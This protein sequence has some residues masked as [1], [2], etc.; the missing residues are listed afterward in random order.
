VSAALDA[1]RA[2]VQTYER[3]SP[4]PNSWPDLHLAY[5]DARQAVRLADAQVPLPQLDMLAALEGKGVL[6]L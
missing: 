5:L 1:C 2:L 6:G 3:V 4:D